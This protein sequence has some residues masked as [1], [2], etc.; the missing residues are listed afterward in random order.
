M[1]KINVE[2]TDKWTSGCSLISSVEGLK[3]ENFSK[4]HD[5]IAEILGGYDEINVYKFKDEFFLELGIFY[6]EGFENEKI[7]IKEKKE[8]GVVG[9]Y[10]G[11]I[12]CELQLEYTGDITF[13]VTGKVEREFDTEHFY[14]DL[15]YLDIPNYDN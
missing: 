2:L 13:V 15:E 14:Y 4:V 1:K 6:S 5:E 9:I 10:S 3:I 7:I 8:D 11:S 12:D